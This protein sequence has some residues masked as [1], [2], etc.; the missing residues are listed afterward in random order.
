MLVNITK[1]VQN[2]STVDILQ[3]ED[4][5]EDGRFKFNINLTKCNSEHFQNDFFSRLYFSFGELL[6]RY[7][8]LSD[9]VKKK[10]QEIAEYKAQGVQLLRRE[11]SN[12]FAVKILLP[13]ICNNFLP[14]IIC[15][16]SLVTEPFSEDLFHTKC[17]NTEAV[18]KIN[19]FLDAMKFYN[20][21]KTIHLDKECVKQESVIVR[22]E[23]NSSR[24]QPQTNFNTKRPAS[25]N[26]RCAVPPKLEKKT[27]LSKQNPELKFL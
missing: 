3:L 5:V 6:R 12:L 10:D 19:V 26:V 14:I 23:S 18:D 24:E 20:S 2:T 9:I 25:S 16:E 17:K 27:K 21:I 8:C 4:K 15:I 7:N 11:F 1:Y 13:S 22:S